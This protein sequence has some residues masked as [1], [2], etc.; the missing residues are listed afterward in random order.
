LCLLIE[1][2]RYILADNVT[3]K[4]VLYGIVRLWGCVILKIFLKKI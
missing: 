2:R 1:K 4:R 3:V